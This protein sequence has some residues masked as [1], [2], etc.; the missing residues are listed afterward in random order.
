MPLTIKQCLLFILLCVCE[1]KTW[2]ISV[3]GT[4]FLGYRKWG[5]VSHFKTLSFFNSIGCVYYLQAI[6]PTYQT[7]WFAVSV[8]DAISKW[9]TGNTF[10]KTMEE[11]SQSQMALRNK[12][13]IWGCLG[14]V[15]SSFHST[16]CTYAI[17][18]CISHLPIRVVSYYGQL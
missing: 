17:S 16:G 12:D 3:C 13:V 15:L 5:K 8:P 1:M 4:V 14:R 2:R 9:A 10:Y 7:A 6:R 18:F 11:K